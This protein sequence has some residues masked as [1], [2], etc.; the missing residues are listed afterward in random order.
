[1]STYIQD[2]TEQYVEEDYASTEDTESSPDNLP[3]SLPDLID[4]TYID[5]AD[6]IITPT[7]RPSQPQN[8]LDKQFQRRFQS[9]VKIYYLYLLE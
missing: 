7:K 2:N 9:L 1:M 3:E 5:E 8:E 6:F 4:T